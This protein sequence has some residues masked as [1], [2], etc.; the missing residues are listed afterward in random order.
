MNGDFA[1]RS[2]RRRKNE[3]RLG[4]MEYPETQK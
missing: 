4:F 3:W 2:I 1:S